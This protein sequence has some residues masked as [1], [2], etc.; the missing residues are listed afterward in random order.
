MK[1]TT[2]KDYKVIYGAD[3]KITISR[4]SKGADGLYHS[5]ITTRC[6][7]PKKDADGNITMYRP[8]KKEII[9]DACKTLEVEY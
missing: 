8:T 4:I 7:I 2:E 9:M 3:G 1:K 5:V 6:Y